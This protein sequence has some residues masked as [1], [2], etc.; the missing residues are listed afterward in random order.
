MPYLNVN[1]ITNANNNGAV[2]ALNGVVVPVGFAVTCSGSIISSGTV[3]A[4]SFSGD[5]SQLTALP[6]AN[7]KTATA[8]KYLFSFDSCLRA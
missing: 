1:Q 5:G 2:T 4:G 8:Y 7:V 6:L 3:T